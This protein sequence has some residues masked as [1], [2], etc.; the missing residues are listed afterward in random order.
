MKNLDL[1]IIDSHYFHS[2][3][4][5]SDI[6]SISDQPDSDKLREREISITGKKLKDGSTREVSCITASQA[7]MRGCI[8]YQY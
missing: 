3:T 5:E 2:F 6:S 8:L 1:L 4:F 7:K